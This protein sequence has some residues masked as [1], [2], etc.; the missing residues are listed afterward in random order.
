M[1]HVVIAHPSPDLYGSDLQM[2]ESVT[3][4]VDDGWQVSLVMPSDGPLAPRAAEAGAQVRIAD[5]PV[6]RKALLH[7]RRLF[8]FLVAAGRATVAARR[9]LR[10]AGADVLYVN[11]LTL[12]TWVLAGRLAGVRVLVHVHEAEEDAPLVVRAGLTAPLLAAHRVVANSRTAAAALAR[13]FGALARRTQVVY[14]GVAGP[15]GP[16][17][18]PD[19]GTT[20]RLLLVGRLSPRK[21]SDVALEA[22]A[23]LVADGRDVTIDLAGTAFA[24][25]EWFA[26]GLAARAAEP[27]LAGRVRL[28][29]YVADRWSALADADVV[30]VPSRVE[31]FGN[32]AVEAMLAAR[33][34]VVS[35]TQGLVEI[36]TADRTGLLVPVADADALAGAVARLADDPALAA[37]LADAGRREA[38]DRFGVARYARELTAQLD[39]LLQ[40]G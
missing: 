36:V 18:P 6:L 19:R 5:F 40:T 2:L 21:G 12:P 22:V 29:G 34:V 25:Y 10:Q 24:G 39:A 30:L 38:L 14:N 1:K 3:A 37:R 23:R 15:P 13:P 4:A 32:T 7:P 33:P 8:G 20:V 16:P 9:W 11:T 28:L 27:D 31:P 35:A 17:S 26:D